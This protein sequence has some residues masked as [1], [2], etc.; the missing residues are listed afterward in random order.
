MRYERKYNMYILLMTSTYKIKVDNIL[1]LW[2]ESS[3]QNKEEKNE[4]KYWCDKIR[5]TLKMIFNLSDWNIYLENHLKSLDCNNLED[6]ET[7]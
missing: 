2:E 6:D 5:E 3:F 7:K 4:L 1:A